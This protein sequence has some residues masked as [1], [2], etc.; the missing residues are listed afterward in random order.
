MNSYF[1]LPF[2]A[3]LYPFN[4]LNYYTSFRVALPKSYEMYGLRFTN[5]QLDKS[6]TRNKIKKLFISTLVL[7]S[8]LVDEHSLVAQLVRALHW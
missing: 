4:I 3:S 6:D 2:A 7:I 5:Y 8:S 1:D